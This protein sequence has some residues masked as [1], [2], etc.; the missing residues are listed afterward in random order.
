MA[1]LVFYTNPQ[2]RGRMVRRMLEECDAKYR[3]EVVPFGADM[4]GD[5][6]REINPLGKVP[7]LRAGGRVV[8]ETPA[9]ICYLADLYPQAGL[10]PP[11]AERQAYY[12]WFFFA[13]GPLEAAV[14]NRALG[15]DVP[16]EKRGFVG[17]G[18]FELVVTALAGA[19]ASHD[20]IA[21]D[22]FTAADVYVGSHV[23]YGLRFGMLPEERVFVAY[24]DRLLGR[25]AWKRAADLDDALLPPGTQ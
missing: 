21:G 2:S 12:R 6:Y 8:T 1:E 16:E 18:S 3:T 13:A 10:A 25:E 11:P 23:E 22:E 19:L 20:Y 17:Y 9:I 14:T 15:V 4:H 5:G 7:A 24:R